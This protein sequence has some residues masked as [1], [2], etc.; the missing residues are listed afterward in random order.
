MYYNVL[1]YTYYNVPT[2]NYNV[3]KCTKMYYEVL[4]CSCEFRVFVG[5]TLKGWVMPKHLDFRKREKDEKT[6][7]FSCHVRKF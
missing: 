6:F 3:L 5:E 1:Q 2:I 4:F 7:T